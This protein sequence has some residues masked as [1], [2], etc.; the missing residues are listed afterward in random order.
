MCCPKL[1]IL[2]VDASQLI[3]ILFNL[4]ELHFIVFVWKRPVFLCYIY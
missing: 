3:Q 4:L 2:T 1:W